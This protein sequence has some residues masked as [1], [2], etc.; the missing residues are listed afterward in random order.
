MTK[1]SPLFQE[2]QGVVLDL[3][4]YHCFGG[5]NA[6]AALPN[7]WS[8]HLDAACDYGARVDALKHPAVT[9]E[10]SLEITD[11]HFSQKIGN[12]SAKFGQKQWSELA[13][14][15]QKTLTRE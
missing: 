7:G 5:W 6:I 15:G 8:I 14:C 3:H 1:Y 13:A 9:G 11:C 12:K 4:E 10:Y 2:Y